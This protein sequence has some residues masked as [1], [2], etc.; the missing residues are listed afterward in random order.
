[1]VSDNVYNPHIAITYMYIRFTALT[2][3]FEARYYTPAY[4]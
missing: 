4:L 2:I 1:M 3:S